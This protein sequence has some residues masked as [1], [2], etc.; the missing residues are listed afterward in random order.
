MKLHD[1]FLMY[2]PNDAP[3]WMTGIVMFAAI[4]MGTFMYEDSRSHRSVA[5]AP[6]EE[7]TQ[8][9]D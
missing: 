4:I 1:S 5:P 8:P 9:S 2:I 7:I 3:T 6:I